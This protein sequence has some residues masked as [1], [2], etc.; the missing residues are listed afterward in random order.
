VAQR[1]DLIEVKGRVLDRSKQVG[2]E[3]VTVMSTSGRWT[4][5]DT[6]GYYRI[7]LPFTDTLF[8]SYQNKETA[9]FPVAQM[10]DP[11]QFSL[12]M[13]VYIPTLPNVIVRAPRYQ[14]DS[15]MN[16]EFY[17]KIF[18]WQKPNPLKTINVGPT[19]V[20]MD[21]NAII[22]LFRFRHNRR[23]SEL[24]QRLFQEE[25]DKYIDFRFNKNLVKKLT[26]LDDEPLQ[27]F[28]VKYR[29]PYDFCALSNELEMGYY[30]QQC[31][32][33][34]TGRLPEGKP[35]FLQDY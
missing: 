31:Y 24:Q 11:A 9:R 16:R 30:I 1:N 13:H 10:Q 25:Q 26:G 5:T 33:S 29:P 27:K 19:G 21:P 2:L 32:R 14:I 34:E 7:Q 15:M 23:I 18:D 28:M 6:L 8:F 20:G 35:Y 4:M 22:N 3:A 12:A 17:A